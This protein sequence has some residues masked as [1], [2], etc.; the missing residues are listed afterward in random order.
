MPPDAPPTPR[1]RSALRDASW[2]G[3]ANVAVKPVWLLF[4]VSAAPRVLG[5]DEYGSMQAALALAGLA[6]GFSDLGVSAHTLRESARDPE[7]GGPLLVNML[8]TRV[9]A[10]AAC[11]AVGLAAALVLGYRGGALGAIAAALV[12]LAGQ[13]LTGFGR[14]FFRSYQVLHLE[15]WSTVAEK[16]LVVGAGAVGLVAVGTAGGTLSAMA[17]ALALVAAAQLRWITRRLVSLRRAWLDASFARRAVWLAL[18]LGAADVLLSVYLRT[19]QVMIE[20]MLGD[21]AAGQY[22]QAYRILEALGLLPAVVVQ[23]SLFPRLSRLAGGGSGVT[24][25]RLLAKVGGGLAAVAVGVAAVLWAV[26]EP[27]ILWLTGDPAFA[28]AGDALGVLA[29]TFPFTCVKDVL[30]IS[31]LAQRRHGPAVALFGA[32]VLLNVGLNAAAIPAYGIVGA[33]AVPLAT[34]VFVVG[35]FL[36]FEWRQAR[37]AAPV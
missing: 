10:V 17:A 18:P 7:A 5:V 26:S 22:G 6:M 20:A 3:I 11:G 12:Y 29:W 1:R 4:M 24:Y 27:L 23:A 19:D 33:S 13:H 31:F 15:A 2:L 36:A 37:A 35:A 16:A 30:F 25:R 9:A 14:I 34:E 28:P 21:R 32:A 8:A